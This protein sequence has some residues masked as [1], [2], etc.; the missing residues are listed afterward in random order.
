MLRALSLLTLLVFQPAGATTF[1]E[2]SFPDA[3]KDAPVVVRGRVGTSYA[4]WVTGPDGTRRIFTF[5]ELTVDEV[6][7]GPSAA[8][9]RSLTMRELGGE[10]D[11]V[12][13]QVA[14]TAHF[15]QGEDTVVFHN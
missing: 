4:N 11:G 8:G 9:K 15:N 6:L 10:K 1:M 5:I 14:G 7:K 3:V 12:G 13:M 2:R